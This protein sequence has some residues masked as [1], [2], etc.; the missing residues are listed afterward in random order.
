MFPKPLSELFQLDVCRTVEI[1]SEICCDVK[2]DEGE[3]RTGNS[4][5]NDEYQDLLRTKEWQSTDLRRAL[6]KQ[7]CLIESGQTSVLR[8]RLV[9]LPRR[10]KDD[11]RWELHKPSKVKFGK[12]LRRHARITK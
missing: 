1:S 5:E 12:E 10:L 7:D 8:R 11:G 6:V 9:G 4:S 2:A 3:V